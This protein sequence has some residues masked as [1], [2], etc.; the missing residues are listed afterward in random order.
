MLLV[1]LAQVAMAGISEATL[2]IEEI[3]VVLEDDLEVEVAGVMIVAIEVGN[4]IAI[5]VVQGMKERRR[6]VM[7]VAGIVIV[8]NEMRPLEAADNRHH[9]AEVGHQATAVANPFEILQQVKMLTASLGEIREMGHH[10][11]ARHL[12]ILHQPFVPG[13]VEGVGFADAEEEHT[14]MIS[15][16]EIRRRILI[17]IVEHSHPRHRPRKFLRLVLLRQV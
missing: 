16:A 11:S 1:V 6:S 3:F 8:G 15:M 2:V 12:Q 13:M 14:T 7:N 10:L 17:G 5:I 4:L 9:L